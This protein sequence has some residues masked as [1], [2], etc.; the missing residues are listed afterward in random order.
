MRKRLTL[1]SQTESSNSKNNENKNFITSPLWRGNV[2]YFII[3]GML[4]PRLQN[5]VNSTTLAYEV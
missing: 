2:T 4:E 3:S 1:F 5:K